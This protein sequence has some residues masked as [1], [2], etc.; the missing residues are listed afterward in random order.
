MLYLDYA[1]TTPPYEEVVETVAEVMKQHYGNPSSIHRLGMQAEKLV[2]GSK[3]IVAGALGVRADEIICTSC[4]TESNNLAIKSAAYSYRNRGDHLITTVIEHPSVLEVFRQLE[5]EGFRVTYLPVDNKGIVK[6]DELK[7]AV[8][9]ETTLVSIMYVN[10]EVGS[11]QPIREIGR[12]LTDYPKI[13]FH[14][15]AVQAIAKL[16]FRPKEWRVDLCSGSA[17]K[18]RGPK[19]VGFLYRRDGIQLKPQLAG[20]GQEYGVRSGTEN[21]PLIVGMAKALRLSMED[22]EAKTEH[23]YRIRRRIVQ[24]IAAIPELAITGSE[25]EVEAA[26]HIVHFSFSGMRAEVVV[27]AL[28]QRNIYVSTKSAC[29]SGESD[30]SLVMLAMGCSREQAASGLR[31]SFSEEHTEE[32]ADQLITALRHVVNELAPMLNVP[33]ARRGKRR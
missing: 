1:A 15:D 14:V 7:E 27:H 6:L 29:S 23:R 10:N 9:D 5:Q 25:L 31:I 11:I 17:H 8:C 19:G 20:G 26:P 32:D 28:E 30:P 4:G 22:M 33:S 21:V 3:E 18:F 13:I 12:I 24:G 2:Q 16:P